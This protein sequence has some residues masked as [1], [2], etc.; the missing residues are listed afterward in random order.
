MTKVYKC[1]VGY[2]DLFDGEVVVHLFDG[3]RIILKYWE[4]LLVDTR[5]A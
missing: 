4:G 2:I 3:I 1:G 5:T